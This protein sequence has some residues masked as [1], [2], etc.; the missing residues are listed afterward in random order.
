MW[1]SSVML[2]C[3]HFK[4]QTL[5]SINELPKQILVSRHFIDEI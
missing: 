1:S 4:M 5:E 2:F 3:D